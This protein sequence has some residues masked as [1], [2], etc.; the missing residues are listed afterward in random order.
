[1][2]AGDL[3]RFLENLTSAITPVLIDLFLKTKVFCVCL[4]LKNHMKAKIY[5]FQPDIPDLEE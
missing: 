2:A 1:M 5:L 4:E 3:E